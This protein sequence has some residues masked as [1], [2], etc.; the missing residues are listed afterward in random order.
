MER[1][2]RVLMAKPG[3]DGHWRGAKIVTTA[4]RN[5]GMEVIFAGNISPEAIVKVAVQ[6]DVNVV[7][8][9]ILAAGHMRI[10]QRA[11]QAFKEERVEDIVVMVG[12]TI[13][14]EDIPRLKE[15]GVDGVF[16]PGSKTDLIVKFVEEKMSPKNLK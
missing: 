3:I 2:I 6:E 14:Q 10:I 8:L 7:G 15:L 4:L 5:A 12:G 9:S 16:P 11:L 13:P 1:K